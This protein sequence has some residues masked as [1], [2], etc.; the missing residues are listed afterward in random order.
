MKYIVDG[1]LVVEGINDE[2]FL[3]SFLDVE[4]VTTN[5]YDIPKEE[6]SYLLEI[7]K[8]KKIIIFTDPDEAGIKIRERLNKLLPNSI[9]L[10]IDINKCNKHNKH[11]VAECTKEEILNVLKPYLVKSLTRNTALSSV[12]LYNLGLI[13]PGSKPNK[14]KIIK[15]FHLGRC[16]GNKLL[17]RI[18]SL[19]ITLEKLKE[20]INGN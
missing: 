18:N 4:I 12:D 9:N 5:G 3:S 8:L 15:H 17:K 19:Q 13:G 20:I 2:A 1:L 14:E 6:V 10:T 11:G 7:S 16:T